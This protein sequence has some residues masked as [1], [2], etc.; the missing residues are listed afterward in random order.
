MFV[1]IVKEE[2]KD[3]ELMTGTVYTS[4]LDYFLLIL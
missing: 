3:I 2:F 1:K 4:K